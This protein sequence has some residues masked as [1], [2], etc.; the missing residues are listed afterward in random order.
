MSVFFLS[1]QGVARDSPAP[2]LAPP[3]TRGVARRAELTSAQK[4]SE[5]LAQ[6]G[7]GGREVAQLREQLAEARE[8]GAMA[9]V[10]VARA[11]TL[12]G[13][14]P[15]SSTEH[16]MGGGDAQRGARGVDMLTSLEASE[17]QVREGRE[18][19]SQLEARLDA[20]A[21]RVQ[22][23]DA[24][25]LTYARGQNARDGEVRAREAALARQLEQHRVQRGEWRAL[26]ARREA[27]LQVATV[28]GR[29]RGRG[30][31]GGGGGREAALQVQ[32]GSAP[33]TPREPPPPLPPPLLGRASPLA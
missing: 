31:S 30:R 6:G 23:Q 25:L 17:Q 27:A 29:G 28:W 32:R 24:L 7:G 15:R 1:I 19:V 14:S 22:E 4:A 11:L 12:A 10:Q 16:A 21:E 26:V 13:R 8:E 9:K 5:Y 33:R 18:L 20:Q 2:L 3:L